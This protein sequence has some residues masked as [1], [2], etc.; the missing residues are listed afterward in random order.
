MIVTVQSRLSSVQVSAGRLQEAVRELTLI[1]V[2]D[3]P[4][5][6]TVH[7]LDAVSDAA[8]ELSSHA[9]LAATKLDDIADRRSAP[10]A[11]L[12]I[13]AHVNHLGAALTADLAA[14]ERL[15]ELGG[16]GHRHGRE[17]A[18]WADEVV[19]CVQACQQLIWT[20]LQPALLGFWEE[21]TDS[22]GGALRAPQ[23]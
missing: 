17:S 23:P 4:R 15:A 14:P 11:V 9:E 13:H 3:R 18:A 22:D 21:I 1:A 5:G 2:E 16:F 7:L 12:A 8:L 20:D 19:R 10:H 6:V